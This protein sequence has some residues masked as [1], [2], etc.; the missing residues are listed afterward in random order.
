MFSNLELEEVN[1]TNTPDPDDYVGKLR[2]NYYELQFRIGFVIQKFL[3]VKIEKDICKLD[4][5]GLMKLPKGEWDSVLAKKM[6][7]YNMPALG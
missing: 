6:R 2:H 5:I 1:R 4:N 7:D 3:L